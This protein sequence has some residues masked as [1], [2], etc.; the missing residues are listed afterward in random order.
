MTRSD[1][2]RRARRFVGCFL[3]IHLFSDS[4]N[5]F[6]FFYLKKKKKSLLL[7]KQIGTVEHLS[8]GLCFAACIRWV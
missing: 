8:P 7:L 6:S 2:L 5:N 1:L 4:L 3:F